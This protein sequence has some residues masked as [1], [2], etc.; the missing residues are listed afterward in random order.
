[1][2]EFF[3]PSNKQLAGHRLSGSSETSRAKRA[4]D[5]TA[6]RR[7]GSQSGEGD[8]YEGGRTVRGKMSVS[9]AGLRSVE[10]HRALP[11]APSARTYVLAAIT[12]E[13]IRKGGRSRYKRPVFAGKK[14]FQATG[15]SGTTGGLRGGWAKPEGGWT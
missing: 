1:V 15:A 12:R 10:S 5:F 7:D 11:R 6:G 8:A 4:G 13:P 9:G 3:P 14:I 2:K